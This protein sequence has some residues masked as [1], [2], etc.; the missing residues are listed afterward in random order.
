MKTIKDLERKLQK[1]DYKQARL[2]LFCNFIALMLISSYSA[3]MLSPTVQLVFPEGGDSRKQ[4]IAI[5]ALTLFGC[6]VF[7]IYAASLFFRKKSKQLGVLMALG[8]SKKRLAPGLFKEVLLLSSAAS[9]A[10]ILAGFPLVWIL[11]NGFRFLIVDSS[12]MVLNLSLKCLFIPALFALLVVIFSLALANRYLV[13]TDILDVIREE[14]KNEPVKTP[15]KWCGPVG[16][17]LIF[18]GFILGY[19]TPGLYMEV[20]SA[21]PPAWVNLSY[22]PVFVGLYLVVLHTVVHGWISHR[23]APYKNIISRSMMKFQG[24]QTVNNLLVGTVLIAGACFASC[25]IFSVMGPQLTANKPKPYAYL[26]PY[27]ADQDMP[28]REEVTEIAAEHNVSLKD[29]TEADYAFL[30]F[31]GES[32]YTMPDGHFKTVYNELSSLETCM[33]EATFNHITGQSADVLPGTFMVISD[34][35]EVA[36][37]FLRTYGSLITNPVTKEAIHTEFAGFLHYDLL[38]K[39][40]G[41]MVLDDSDYE[42]ISPGLTG[43][44]RGKLSLFNINEEDNYDFAYDLFRT[45]VS[46]TDDSCYMPYY[47]DIY[48]KANREKAGLSYDD[49]TDNIEHFKKSNPDSTTFRTEWAYMPVF[50]ILNSHDFLMTYSVYIMMF[51]FIFIVCLIAACIILHTRCQ[52]IALNNRYLFEDLKRLGASPAFLTWEVKKQCTSVFLTP[53]IVGVTAMG[54]VFFMI[55]FINDNRISH[56]EVTSILFCIASFVVLSIFLYGV[57]RVTV[58][59]IKRQL[60]L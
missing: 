25:Y 8:A 4:M 15:G 31:D 21:M 20:F 30:A 38:F 40:N 34:T 60:S 10:G 42:K 52:T 58:R 27:R 55:L 48:T 18:A 14:H 57:Y 33:S 41:Y 54:F 3:L 56:S 32:Q 35:E 7:T 43:E 37:Y 19:Y 26:F 1:T 6:G 13:R 23:K 28:D 12:D 36:T 2:Y 9:I 5:F 46:S 53:S 47:I 24:R 49:W 44:Y 17:L 51:L 29:W 11:W 50:Q 22:A 16:F 45:I 39:R 59:E